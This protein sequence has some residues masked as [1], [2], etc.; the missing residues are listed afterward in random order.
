MFFRSIEHLKLR[1]AGGRAMLEKGLPWTSYAH[2]MYTHW[3]ESTTHNA[4]QTFNYHEQSANV[5]TRPMRGRSGN[6]YAVNLRKMECDC[7]KWSE[8]GIPCS[9][10][11]SVCKSWDIE[12]TNYVKPYYGIHP[13]LATYRGIYTPVPR[14][15]YW[16]TPPLLSCSITKLY[17]SVVV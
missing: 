17:V 4:V 3:F 8:F 5:F 13:Y 10:V 16:D 14:E 11:Q 12:A 15:H 6:R 7:G 9:H 2:K 1:Y